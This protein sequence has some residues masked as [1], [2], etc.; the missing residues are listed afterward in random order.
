M[1]ADEID[2]QRRER[3]TELAWTFPSM[4]GAPGVNPWIPEELNRWALRAVS[5]GER[6]TARFLLSVW[7]QHT[8]WEAGRFDVMDA[9]GVW[10]LKHRAA[11]LKWASDPWWA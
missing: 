6:V 2:E 4:R 9:L 7:D 11:F 1:D 10:D 5:H 3:M 8:D